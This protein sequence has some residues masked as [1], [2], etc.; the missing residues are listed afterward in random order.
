M[1]L[2][3]RVDEAVFL[4][5]NIQVVVRCSGLEK[6]KIPKPPYYPVSLGKNH[7]EFP[8]NYKDTVEEELD[9]VLPND[10]WKNLG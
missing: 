3:G 7:F 6:N 5:H 8:V 10:A 9:K 4:E 2:V 1:Q